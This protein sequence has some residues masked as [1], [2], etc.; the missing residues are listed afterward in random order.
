MKE[1]G[2]VLLS[3]VC[4]FHLSSSV[5]LFLVMQMAVFFGRHQKQVC[6]KLCNV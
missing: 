6:V 4:N 1:E 3:H 2:R 5:D